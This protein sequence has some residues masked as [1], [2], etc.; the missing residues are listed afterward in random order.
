MVSFLLFGCAHSSYKAAY[1]VGAVTK[2]FTEN[3]YEEYKDGLDIKLDKCNPENNK[4]IK[5]KSD[6]DE[7]MGRFYK[8]EDFTKIV[9]ALG[10]YKV[11]ARTLT[12]ILENENS[13]TAQKLQAAEEVLQAASEALELFPEGKELVKKLEK[14]VSL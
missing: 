3:A 8:E 10:I 1:T 5:T 6:F 7:C 2:D 4:S 11:A 9:Q 14:L 12:E 13:T